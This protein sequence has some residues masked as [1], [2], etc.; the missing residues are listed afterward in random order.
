M[1]TYTAPIRDMLFVM[2][3]LAGLDTVAALPGFEEVPDLAEAVLEEAGKL[4]GEVL[5]PL[6]SDT[7]HTGAQWT[8]D[9]VIAAEGFKD[10][11]WQFV[12]G[13]WNGLSCPAEF[14]G[15]GLPELLGT[16][17]HE[18]WQAANMSFALCP[19]LTMGA[20][21]AIH[22]HASDELK[23]AYLPKMVSGEWTGTMN[24]TE[25][26]AG[27]DLS[28]VRSK[29]VPEGDHYLVSGQKIFITW[30]D[31]DMTENTIHLVLARL[32]DAPEGVK[33]I[34]LFVCP[35][36]LLDADGAPAQ[37]NTV[38]CVS[39][40]HKLGIHGSPTCV[41]AFEDAVGYLV[42][43]PNKGLGYMFTMMNEARLKVGLQGLA[44]SDR[45]YQLALSYA[46]ERVQGRPANAKAGDR[47]AIIGHA[48]IRRMLL[49]MKS[50]TEAMRAIAY[51]T[52]S[53]MD[54]ARHS[55]D[56]AT[57]AA[58][59]ARVDLM[60]PIVKAWS[61]EVGQEVTSLGVQVHG[62]MGYVEETGAA[63]F[64]RD[65][66]ITTIYEGTTAIQANDFVGRKVAHDGGAALG[67]LLNEMKATLEELAA[68]PGD[69]LAAIR[70]SLTEGVRALEELGQWVVANFKPNMVDVLGEAVN[71][72]MLA[73]YV[74]GGWQLA[75]AAL[76]ANAKLAAGEDPAFYEAKVLTARFY[77]E[78][79]LPKASSLL[80][81]VKTGARTMM[82][83]TE[84]QF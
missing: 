57:A 79:L 11:Y 84:E 9:G 78:Q 16:A 5:A 22:H 64:L 68:A 75:R 72:V 46:K 47:T 36:F 65:A 41:L 56:A 51:T 31:H 52:A 69:D 17:T 30:G 29:A 59:Q 1:S 74:C 43:E 27:S 24:L 81:T 54:I 28:A 76:V 33:G 26:Q 2:T 21:E 82:A 20:I 39:I 3:E 49:T 4:A 25:P 12:E 63:Q 61:T 23:A 55:E 62:G 37:R 13:G 80:T 83:L 70:A 15:Q 73:G 40:E 50:Q 32:P 66:R 34:S 58:A 35:K 71:A 6:N 8:A 38:Q 19:M 60:I 18:M 7:G 45:A 14:E 67:V 42:G 44:I 77:A 10:A 53:Y 48:D